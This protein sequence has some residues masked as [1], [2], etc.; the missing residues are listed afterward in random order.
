MKMQKTILFA[1]IGS[2]FLLSACSSHDDQ[3][4]YTSKPFSETVFNVNSEHVKYNRVIN[5]GDFQVVEYQDLKSNTVDPTQTV[6]VV[7]ALDNKGKGAIVAY[8]FD[9][10]LVQRYIKDPSKYVITTSQAFNGKISEDNPA[11]FAVGMDAV[12]YATMQV[13][14]NPSYMRNSL[15]KDNVDAVAQAI[16]DRLNTSYPGAFHIKEV[17]IFK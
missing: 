11:Q 3:P 4:R 5:F 9:R 10:D 6:V 7:P 13:V 14:G 1:A 2:A 17:K 15:F 12:K 8:S 16:Q